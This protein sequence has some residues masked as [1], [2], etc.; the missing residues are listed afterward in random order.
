MDRKIEQQLIE[1]AESKKRMPLLLQGARQVGKSYQP[2]SKP[3]KYFGTAYNQQDQMVDS[4]Y[5]SIY[6][7]TKILILLSIIIQ[8]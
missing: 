4:S 1:W 8:K 7:V 2:Q 6:F 3:E 5:S